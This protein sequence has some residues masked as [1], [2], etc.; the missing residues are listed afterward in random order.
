[1]TDCVG[2]QIDSGLVVMSDTRTNAGMDS[3]YTYRHMHVC[4]QP[5]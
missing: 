5:G 2:L 4:A 1:M 3:F